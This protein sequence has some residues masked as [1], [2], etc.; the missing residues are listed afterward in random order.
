MPRLSS[1]VTCFSSIVASLSL[2]APAASA[3]TPKKLGTQ[4]V[5]DR[6][7]FGDNYRKMAE[8]IEGKRRATKDDLDLI[9][10]NAQYFVLRITWYDVP[11][12]TMERVQT[13]FEREVARATGPIY[14]KKNQEF[15]QIYGEHLAKHFE[16]VLKLPFDEQNRLAVLNAAMM[17]PE[18]AKLEA[19]AIGDLLA[20]VIQDP[21]TSHAV[22]IH[23]LKAMGGQFPPRT[24]TDEDFPLIDDANK[25][26]K[27]RDLERIQALL[28]YIGRK[29]SPSEADADA[30]RMLRR[31]AIASLAHAETPALCSIKRNL[32]VEG[33]VVEGLLRILARDGGGLN[34]PPGLLERLEAAI[35]VCR[36][37]LEKSPN[38]VP[39]PGLYLL[40]EFLDDWMAAYQ[41]DQPNIAGEGDKGLPATFWKIHT[42]AVEVALEDL[43]RNAKNSSIEKQA[44]V[45]RDR[46]APMVKAVFPNYGRLEPDLRNDLRTFVR[47]LRPKTDDLF[48]NV[49]GPKAPLPKAE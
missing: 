2:M 21:K 29:W 5:L 33:P 24:I 6:I 35:G 36:L 39:E 31:A 1:I 38:Y 49:T 37:N 47:S 12:V 25:R 22:K 18:A 3:Q 28:D 44:A 10:K 7:R 8:L 30:V 9:D 43:V 23:A 34:P 48:R 46:F 20:K 26:K 16:S 19:E 4:A 32:K 42:K 41:A 17:L 15:L 45:L 27:A 14:R 11:S 40:G 13:D